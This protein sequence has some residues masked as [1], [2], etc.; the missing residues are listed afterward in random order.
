MEYYYTDGV[1]NFG[2]YTLDQLKEKNLSP[3]TRIWYSGLSGWTAASELPELTGLF[4][5]MNA[6]NATPPPAPAIS[7]R[8]YGTIPGGV[9][10]SWFIEAILVTLFCCQ[11]FGVV[12]IV[13]AAL[14][15][16]AISA[17]NLTEAN[18]VS[19]LAAK[20][21]KIG[22]ICGLVF[23]VLFAIFYGLILATALKNVPNLQDI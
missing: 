8:T 23:F 11:P 17:G 12:A 2:P 16:S 5:A 22:F 9:P 7:S 20:W 10:K 1:T 6:E 15:E 4:S 18:R 21:V 3:S 13:Y 14:V 19:K